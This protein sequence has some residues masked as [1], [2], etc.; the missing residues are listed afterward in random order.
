[1]PTD[2]ENGLEAAS[3]A[4]KRPRNR[5]LRWAIRI[6]VAGGLAGY[7][8]FVG[9]D[10]KF[11]Y[12]SDRVY[13]EPEALGLAYEDVTFTTPDGLRLHGWFLPAV[14]EVL[15]TVVH[16]HGN[17][18]N[19]TAHLGLAAWLPAEGYNVLMFD[20]RGYGKSEGRVTRS[21]TIVDGCAAV[22]YVLGR[23]DVDPERVFIYGQSLGG[24]V[25]IVVAAQ[26]PAIR[27]VAVEGTFG[28]YR[29]IAAMHAQRILRL[30]VVAEGLARATVSAGA[31][32]IDVVASLSPRPI[33]IIGGA[34]DTTCFPELSRALYEAAREPKD[35]W[36]VPGAQH[37]G[38]LMVDYVG[39]RDRVKAV[40]ARG[41]GE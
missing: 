41:V 33:L 24:A 7:V 1:M 2:A 12:P 23:P 34:E 14:G 40:F 36:I 35:L 20:Y 16:F 38:A 29:G 5:R 6:L 21:G 28:S 31:D 19:I 30:G 22:D 13:D 27:A 9:F 8:L 4:R 37:M 18:A 32:P 11:Y 39:L 3:G 15:G 25:G 26:R 10:S 17:A